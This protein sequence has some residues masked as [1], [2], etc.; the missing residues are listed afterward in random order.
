MTG[1]KGEHIW[2]I[3]ASSGIG[4]AL[5]I[6]LARSG[7][8]LSLSARSLDKLGELILE[9]GPTHSFHKLDVTDIASINSAIDALPGTPDRII[10]MAGQYEPMDIATM[11]LQQASRIV[12]TN[13]TGAINLVSLIL[14]HLLKK[15][16]G[17][18]ALTASV[19][20]YRGLPH[21][22]PYGATKAALI[23]FAETLA[24][25]MR[26]AG[27]DVKIINPGFVRTA[28]TDKNEFIMPMMISPEEAAR[29][30]VKG[31]CETGFEIHFPKK[32]TYL[33]KIIGLL[34]FRLYK[35]VAPR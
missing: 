10:Y 15:K 23:N 27:I 21:A 3:G 29:S 2:I 14:P 17:Q 18:I 1:V 33:M 34:P 6:E 24:L 22:Q 19:A 11:D 4:R 32:F 25:E 16:R 35:M 9:I 31:L 12:E 5:A 7:A 8:R 26:G 28:L 30:I 13:L 20:G